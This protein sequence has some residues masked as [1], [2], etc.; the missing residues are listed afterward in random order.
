MPAPSSSRPGRAWFAGVRASGVVAHVDV[1]ADPTALATPGWWALVGT[2]EGRVE[3][4]RFADVRPA[5]DADVAA[6]GPGEWHGPAR[7]AWTTSLGR[8]AYV[9]AVQRV[10]DHVREGDVYQANLCRVLSAPLPAGAA[11]PDAG[12]LAARLAAGNPAPYAGGVHVPASDDDPG[13]WVVT[14]SPELFLRIQDGTLTSAP[15]KGT[16]ATAGGLS[17]KDRA[18]NV[19]ITDLVR[20]DLQ[21]VCRPGTVRVARL[22]DVEEHPGLVHLVSTVT[23]D[24]ADGV[25]SAPDL[26]ARVLDATYPPGSVSGAPKSSALRLIDALEPVPRG[27]YCGLVGWVRVG[28]DG[29]VRAELAV[30]IRTF[31]WAD[32]VLRFGTGAGITWHSDPAAEWAET[33]LKASRLVALASSD[34]PAAVDGPPVAG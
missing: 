13:C 33:E 32:D 20:N 16:A 30:G 1:R 29:D 11:A 15:I 9:A 25:R 18:E 26:V 23:G 4:W 12:A 7:D 5:P 31:W 19:M 8:D 28:R 3:A 14:A 17:P 24:L 22:L 6:G 34:G 10:R 27:P 21:R 2:F